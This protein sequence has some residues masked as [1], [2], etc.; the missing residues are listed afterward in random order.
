MEKYWW[1]N[2][3]VYQIYP[4]SFCDSNGDGIGDL[5][6]I[7][8][9]LDYIQ[10]LGVNVI[11][12][13]PVY[14]S[15][16]V[17]NGYDISDYYSID[18]IFGTMEDFDELLRESHKR[19][20]NIIMDMVVNHC[21]DQHE[22]FQKAKDNPEGKYGK[23]FYLRKR[24]GKIPPNNWRSIFGGSVWSKLGETD[25]D[26]LHIFAPE[27]PDLNWE[28]PDLREEIYNMMNWWLDKG[29][30][31]FR[32]DAI[33]YL[34]KR[35]GLPSYPADGEDGLSA[36]AHGALNQP[37]I[38]KFLTQ[39][40]NCTYGRVNAMT[41]GE[42]SGVK[43]DGLE[44]YVSLENGYFSMIFDFSFCTINLKEPTLFWY[45]QRAWTPDELKERLYATYESLGEKCWIAPC[46]ENHD[47]A[48][49]I[50]FYLPESGQNYYG[51]TMLA[52]M[53][54]MRRG[55]PF[56]YQG[57]ELGMRNI[58]LNCIEKY[59]DLQ[60]IDQYQVARA[61]GKSDKEAMRAVW[62]QSR[63][64]ART[65]FRWNAEKNA[66][67]TTGTPWFPINPEYV[68]LNAE[69]EEK[70]DHSILQ[71]WK[72]LTMLRTKSRYAEILVDG[73]FIPYRPDIKNLLA[74]TRNLNDQSILILCNFSD[75]ELQVDLP[76][77]EVETV[78]DNYGKAIY[79]KEAKLQPFEAVVLSIKSRITNKTKGENLGNEKNV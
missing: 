76:K 51:A 21:S 71:F 27:Q 46:M 63:D 16:M 41:V 68:E 12:L 31:G 40:R 56:I 47:Q 42:A 26:Y 15:P 11:W 37:G 32:M 5:Q 43:G 65:P 28:N 62:H 50:D 73:D 2:A 22:W 6:G 54:M 29:V 78:L 48:R 44:E 61:A 72:K 69:D 9:K 33:T 67:F 36:V 19:E 38:G 4:K 66:G 60:T 52:V 49:E 17:D 7:I 34:K 45:D 18:P 79:G 70:D 8:S 74:Y 53:H 23:Y 1:K 24:N 20:M 77:H 64:N 3:V 58:H 55:T 13:S 10:D 39:M 35:E 30:A 57:Q 59:N 75:K 14:P 25:Y